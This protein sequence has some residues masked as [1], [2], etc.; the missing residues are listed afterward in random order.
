MSAEAINIQALSTF[1]KDVKRLYKKYKNLPDDLKVLNKILKEN[2]L[3]GISLG[4]NLFKVRLANSSIPTGKSGGFRV[5][6][7]YY[8]GGNSLYL[9]T[10][11]S[12]R[13]MENISD[14]KLVAISNNTSLLKVKKT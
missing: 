12:K 1:S 10:L 6:Y 9:A 7:Y 5:V 3:A 11:F 13:D 2:P 8:D 14:E 4:D